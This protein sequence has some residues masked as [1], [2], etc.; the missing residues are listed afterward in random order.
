MGQ[1]T[2]IIRS[3]WFYTR[4]LQRRLGR[5]R[6]GFLHVRSLHCVRVKILNGV[7]PDKIPISSVRFGS[8]RARF[9]AG[10]G[11]VAS[12]INTVCLDVLS[13]ASPD[14]ITEVS[15]AMSSRQDTNDNVARLR[16]QSY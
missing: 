13:F 9:S 5:S 2:D 8:T 6:I 12:A 16:P 14:K 11:E 15:Q 4:S 3:L 10:L 1:N 7:C